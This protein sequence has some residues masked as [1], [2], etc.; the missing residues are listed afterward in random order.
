MTKSAQQSRVRHDREVN[1]KE[2]I[3]RLP[4]LVGNNL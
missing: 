2:K 1:R 4:G 3:A